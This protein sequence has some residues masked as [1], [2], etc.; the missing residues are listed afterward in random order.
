MEIHVAKFK[1]TKQLLIKQMAGF[2]GRKEKELFDAME[3]DNW[4]D[5]ESA[6]KFGLI[7]DILVRK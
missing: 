7:D 3:R 6:K 2:T 4:M 5:S 1:Q